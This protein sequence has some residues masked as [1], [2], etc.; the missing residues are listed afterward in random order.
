MTV[1]GFCGNADD[2]EKVSLDADGDTVRVPVCDRCRDVVTER[3]TYAE[4]NPFATPCVVCT[5]DGAT[6]PDTFPGDWP[7]VAACEACVR[8]VRRWGPVALN[9]SSRRNSDT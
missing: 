9:R 2:G 7:T 1:C 3:S 5:A 8:E 6:I 4:E